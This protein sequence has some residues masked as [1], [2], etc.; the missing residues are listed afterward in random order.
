MTIRRSLEALKTRVRQAQTQAMLSVNRELIQLYWDIGRRIVER[1]EKEGWGQSV[2]DRLAGDLQKAFPGS[3]GFSP[4]NIW[5][6]RAFHLAYR[7]VGKNPSQ[8]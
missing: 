1:Q 4:V 7:D 5:R 3:Q 6:M 2:V 8:P